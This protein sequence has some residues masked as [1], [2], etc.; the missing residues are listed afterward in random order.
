M[1]GPL[2]GVGDGQ[3]APGEHAE[4]RVRACGR[5]RVAT[6]GFDVV[7]LLEVGGREVFV[8]EVREVCMTTR[9]SG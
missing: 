5:E 1:D 3:R 7:R 8:G 9:A 4:A 6:C 2:L